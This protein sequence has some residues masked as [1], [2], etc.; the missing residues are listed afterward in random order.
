MKET[1]MVISLAGFQIQ[2]SKALAAFRNY[3]CLNF[4]F[5]YTNSNRTTI[6]NKYYHNPAC[7]LRLWMPS[8]GRGEERPELARAVPEQFWKRQSRKHVESLKCSARQ[9]STS[10]EMKGSSLLPWEL[11]VISSCLSSRE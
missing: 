5:K 6:S 3:K 8:K 4:L 10:L 2:K 11:E 7:P 1:R 9:I